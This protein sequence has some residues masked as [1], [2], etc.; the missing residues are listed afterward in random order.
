MEQNKPKSAVSDL[1]LRVVGTTI[2]VLIGEGIIA[3]GKFAV[4]KCKA[5]IETKKA[6]IEHPVDCIED[7][8][9]E[10]PAEEATTEA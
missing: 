7:E 4:K 9:T 2:G 3:G 1:I 6:E 10:A 8:G 5:G